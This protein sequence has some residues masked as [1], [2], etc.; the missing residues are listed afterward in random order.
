MGSMS[1]EGFSVSHRDFGE[2]SD[3]RKVQ[4]ITLANRIGVSA[5]VLTYGA[6]L[7]S[8]LIPD[9]EG[10]LGDVVLGHS[11]ITD[12]VARPQYFGATVGRFANRIGSGRFQMDGRQFQL[13]PNGGANALHGGE[14]GLDKVI[15]ELVGAETEDRASL[16][17]RHISPDGD[18]GYPGKLEINATFSLDASN[19][20]RIGYR[21]T[22]TSKTV[23]NITNHTYWNLAGDGSPRGTAD[24]ELQIFAD[25]FLPTD[26]T[27]L[28]TGEFRLVEGTPFDFRTRHAIAERIRDSGDEQIA[29]ARG[30]DQNWIVSPEVV[31]GTQ[32]MAT[33]ADPV[34]GRRLDIWSNQP[35]LQFYSGNFLDGTVEGKA[36]RFY[37]MGDG[38]ALEPQIFPDSPNHAHFPNALLRPGA[39]YHNEMEFRFSIEEQQLG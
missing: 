8:L 4:A 21:A 31:D 24:H 6:T 1:E 2:I 38:L 3:G 29:I 16:T 26:M 25:S 34:S 17:L 32:H 7:Q 22:T 20:F 14:T 23:V 11:T 30:Y 13:Q 5:T 15:W 18:Q 33:L 37:R 28:P 19:T 10:N 35:G 27:A 39:V 36:K 9:R 12:Y